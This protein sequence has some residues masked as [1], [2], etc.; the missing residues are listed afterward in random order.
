MLLFSSCCISKL[1]KGLCALL[2]N[3]PTGV[4]SASRG[5]SA[6]LKL[7]NSKTRSVVSPNSLHHRTLRVMRCDVTAK[8][9][10]TDEFLWTH[11]MQ[12]PSTKSLRML[13]VPRSFL[14]KLIVSTLRLLR[15]L[16]TMSCLAKSVPNGL[17][18]HK[19]KNI[20]LQRKW[21]AFLCVFKKDCVQEMV[22]AF[23]DNHLKMHIGKGTEPWVPIWHSGTSKASPICVGSALRYHA[24][25]EACNK[26]SE[27]KDKKL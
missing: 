26:S 8:F 11:L 16:H 19:C 25:R 17:K 4:T 12:Q 15:N 6:S 1:G 13:A 21:P 20:T 9:G 14:K 7:Q 18:D 3:T 22:S 27:E 5:N 23:K 24:R 10:P 2:Y